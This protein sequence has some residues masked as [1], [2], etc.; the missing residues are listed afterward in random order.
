MATLPLVYCVHGGDAQQHLGKL[1]QL[2]QNFKQEQRIGDFIS[3]LPDDAAG[4]L[5]GRLKVNDLIVLLL[6]HGL[7]AKRKDITALLTEGIVAEIIIDNIPFENEYITLPKDLRPIRDAQN[8]DAAWNEMEENLKQLL[9]TRAVDWKKYLIYVVPIIAV[10]VALLIWRPW[11]KN[12]TVDFKAAF[13]ASSTQCEAPCTVTFKN[14]SKNATTYEW[15]FGDGAASSETNPSHTFS[16]AGT[17]K[18]KLIASKEGDKKD[19]TVEINVV[20]PTPGLKPKA[21]FSSNK[22]SCEAPCTIVF[23][24][25]SE[26]AEKYRWDFGNGAFSEEVSPTH[27]FDNSGSFK[28]KLTALRN[29]Q[30]DA[31]THE[32][33]VRNA[34]VPAP[35]AGFTPSQ[36]NCMTPC[37]ITFTN[38]S[39][40]ATTFSWDFGDGASSTETNPS[41]QYTALGKYQVKLVALNSAGQIDATKTITVGSSVNVARF[42]VRTTGDDARTAAGDDEIDSDDWTSIELSYTIRIVANREIQLTL[43][44][45]AQERNSNR[46]PGNTRFRSSKSFTIYTATPGSV[47][48]KVQGVELSANRE[49]YYQGE[50]HGFKEFRDTGSLQGIKVR[51]DAAGGNDRQQQALTATLVGFSVDLKPSN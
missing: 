38:Q 15:S 19:E 10:L 24:N 3:L 12:Q 48:D 50:V 11:E 36:T 17:Y 39:Q 6:T 42:H 51:V 21:A 27:T 22:T 20:N 5:P 29:D 47:I 44:W 13:T 7:E 37:S 26:N 43:V 18:V 33:V 49:Q 40:N 34:P 45:Y 35:I 23:N 9:P 8:M 1:Q 4:L 41:H 16:K 2:A 31:I 25:S 30:E 46:S 28:V 32:I 14:T